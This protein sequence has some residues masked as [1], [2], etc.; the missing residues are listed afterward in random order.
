ML[1]LINEKNKY[2][3]TAHNS[4]KFKVEAQN[5]QICYQNVLIRV[6]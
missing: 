4:T 3:L 1:D 5:Y 6:D 2:L